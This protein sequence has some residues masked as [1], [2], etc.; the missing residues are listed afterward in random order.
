MPRR[1]AFLLTVGAVALLAVGCNGQASTPAAPALVFPGAPALTVASAS[2]QLTIGVWWS[3]AQPTVGY[4]AAQL[5]IADA[6]GAPVTGLTLT[7]VPWMPAHGHGASVEP[8]VSEISPG[9][10]VA[11]P[12]DFFMAGSWELMTAISRTADAGAS[13]ASANDAAETSSASSAGALNDSAEP[14]VE[15]P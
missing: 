2:G 10:Y 7:I 8:T 5:S 14:M 6:T 12:L 4:D 3:P 11:T 1:R 9:L 15:V 13:D